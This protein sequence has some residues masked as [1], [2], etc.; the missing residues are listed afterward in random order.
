VS[1]LVFVM[2]KW[3]GVAPC[4]LDLGDL[5]WVMRN[6]GHQ[7]DRALAF[8]DLMRRQRAARK[9]RFHARNDS[10]KNGRV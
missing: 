2:G 6:A 1:E 3:K 8:Q 10:R 5:V 7:V 4:D 9:R